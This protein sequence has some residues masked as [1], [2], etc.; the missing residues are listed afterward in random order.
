MAK[1]TRRIYLGLLLVAFAAA[2]FRFLKSSLRDRASGR[3][4]GSFDDSFKLC[5]ATIKNFS[6]SRKS[7]RFFKVNCAMLR[8]FLSHGAS[9]AS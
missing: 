5:E 6:I 2:I 4:I 9:Y 3:I 8:H 1:F 7:G